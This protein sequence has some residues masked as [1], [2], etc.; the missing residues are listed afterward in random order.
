MSLG[1]IFRNLGRHTTNGIVGVTSGT[2]PVGALDSPRAFR[3]VAFF[4][5]TAVLLSGWLIYHNVFRIT[6]LPKVVSAQNTNVVVDNDKL[7]ALQNKDTDGDGISDYDELYISKTSPYLKDSDGDG[8]P[9]GT[10]AQSGTDPNCPEGKICE[11]FRVLTSIVDAKGN[12]TP[13]FLR[14]SLLSAGVPQAALDK[15]DDA[16]LLRIYQEIVASQPVSNTN[17]ANTN[18]TNTGATNQGLASSLNV[19]GV[20]S[21]ADPTNASTT[22]TSGLTLT[23]LQTLSSAEI[24]QL[25][26]DNGIDQATLNSIDDATLKQIYL[27]SLSTNV[28]NQ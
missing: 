26:I 23:Q 20:G 27:E 19:N 6:A 7:L 18:S 9:D 22:A 12:L 24:R 4:G 2:T 17:T 16:S 28:T 5:V 21:I 15:T 3:L 14:K 8:I 10:E 25:L 11:G 13:A 1:S